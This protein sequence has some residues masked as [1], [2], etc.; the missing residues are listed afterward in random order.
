[1]LKLIDALDK[2]DMQ[3]VIILPNNDA[4]ASIVKA[5]I[6]EKRKKELNRDTETKTNKLSLK[7]IFSSNF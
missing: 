2:F 1:M 3:K 5:K 4:G 6:R 7:N